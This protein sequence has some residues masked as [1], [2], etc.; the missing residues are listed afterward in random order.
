GK[1]LLRVSV[2]IESADDLVTDLGQALSACRVAAP[3]GGCH[4]A[5]VVPIGSAA[6][7]PG[8]SRASIGGIG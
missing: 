4:A 5:D 3:E 2:G 8:L 7:E 1:G 6:G